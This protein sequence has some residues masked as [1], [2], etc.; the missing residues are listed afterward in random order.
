M[1]TYAYGACCCP[2]PGWY[3]IYWPGG[4]MGATPGYFARTSNSDDLDGDDNT[5]PDLWACALTEDEYDGDWEKDTTG[6]TLEAFRSIAVTNAD[7]DSERVWVNYKRDD[8]GEEELAVLITSDPDP[9]PVEEQVWYAGDYAYPTSAVR[10]P[11]E[12][13]V[14]MPLP[15][16][17]GFNHRQNFFVVPNGAA[18]YTGLQSIF[19]G[20]VSQFVNRYTLG[21]DGSHTYQ[22]WTIPV[23]ASASSWTELP[24]CHAVSAR[25]W[26]KCAGVRTVWN[27][28]PDSGSGAYDF[29]IDIVYGEVNSF[30]QGMTVTGVLKTWN[31]TG[32]STY[33]VDPNTNK[34]NA[35]IDAGRPWRAVT[36]YI[37]DH[38]GN[39]A[40]RYRV[41]NTN[42]DPSNYTEPL[43]Y[44]GT[45]IIADCKSVTITES[46]G[47]TTDSGWIHNNMMIFT[48]RASFPD[49]NADRIIM[50]NEYRKSNQRCVQLCDVNGDSLRDFLPTSSVMQWKL[51]A[52]GSDAYAYVRREVGGDILLRIVRLDNAFAYSRFNEPMAPGTSYD[53]ERWKH[54]DCVRLTDLDDYTPPLAEA[55]LV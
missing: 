55:D 22:S 49:D 28:V 51:G 54:M 45:Q 4:G 53:A 36:G 8:S 27:N 16:W 25:Y 17:W 40:L 39:Q 10:L 43:D 15:D 9:D 3:D 5:Y 42:S 38:D 34:D 37:E 7:Y 20:S 47:V 30:I 41:G 32:T 6:D 18:G 13:G 44:N 1:S 29:D 23:N 21:E 11:F 33:D 2:A 35:W 48:P 50:A 31:F 14:G 24:R 46:D 52:A 26:P 12:A 19:R